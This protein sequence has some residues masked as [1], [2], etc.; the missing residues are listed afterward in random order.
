MHEIL[1]IKAILVIR[2]F[3]VESLPQTANNG[4]VKPTVGA[5]VF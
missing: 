3:V 2:E 5:F 1:V 4:H